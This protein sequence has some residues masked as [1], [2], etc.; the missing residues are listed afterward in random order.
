MILCDTNI[1]VEFYK[2]TPDILKQTEY[3][4]YKRLAI[5]A[6]TQGE[7]YFGAFDK[8]ELYTLN[9]KD[10]QFIAGI[11]LYQPII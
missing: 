6:I 10:F 8:Y 9:L 3:I 11:K 7:L 4:G 2:N 5:S 1:L